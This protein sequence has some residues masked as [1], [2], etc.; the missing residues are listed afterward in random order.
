[1]HDPAIALVLAASMMGFAVYFM[2][3]NRN[4]LGLWLAIFFAFFVIALL[5]INGWFDWTNWLGQNG[6][7]K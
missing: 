6:N 5:D 2:L 3:R 1:M 7:W 4:I